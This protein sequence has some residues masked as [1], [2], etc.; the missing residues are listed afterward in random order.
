MK[1]VVGM[2]DELQTK[3]LKNEEGRK[4]VA[5]YGLDPKL[6]KYHRSFC[7]DCDKA[8]EI[9]EAAV[10]CPE[11]GGN[12]ITFGVFDRIELVKDKEKTQ[13]P[14][15]RPQYVYQ[16]PL[17]FIPGVGGKTIDKLLEHK[18]KTYAFVGPS[19]TGKSYRAQMVASEYD[20]KVVYTKGNI[21]LEETGTL[22][23]EN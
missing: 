5:N 3:A 6:G 13:S 4:I 18:V 20:I 2:L 14:E 21:K 10:T 22:T 8:I 11:C 15:I 23:V 16:V 19:G 1:D 17:T 7:E 9:D 12:N